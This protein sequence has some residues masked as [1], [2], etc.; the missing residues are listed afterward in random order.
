M[1]RLPDLALKLGKLA[2]TIGGTVLV[3]MMLVTVTDV[4]LRYVWRPIFGTFDMITFGAVLVIGFAM[5]RTS[6]DKTHTCVDIVVE[7]VSP[8]PAAAMQIITRILNILLFLLFAWALLDVARTAVR[9]GEK[10]L[11]ISIPLYIA[12][13]VLIVCCLMECLVHAAAIVK[14]GV[15]G[16]ANE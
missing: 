1:K 4:V 5:P 3:L 8:R 12:P 16:K 9:T 13:A 14:I 7:K 2:D 10:S 6:L 15:S 11:L